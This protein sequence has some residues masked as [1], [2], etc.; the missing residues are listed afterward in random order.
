MVCFRMRINGLERVATGVGRIAK[1]VEHA[2][3][4]DIP[5]VCNLEICMF[6]VDLF[7]GAGRGA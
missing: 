5:D 6:K 7:D 2:E 1:L 4:A 3:L